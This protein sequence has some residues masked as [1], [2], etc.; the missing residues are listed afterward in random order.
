MSESVKP[1]E[2]LWAW[3]AV[4]KS[5]K[6]AVVCRQGVPLVTGSRSFAETEMR[7]VADNAVVECNRGSI[8]PIRRIVLRS[9]HASV[10]D[11]PIRGITLAIN[12]REPT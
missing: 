1:V 5:G 3:I 7:A 9:F 11:N 6:E 2:T 12:A 8:D 4:L 10:V